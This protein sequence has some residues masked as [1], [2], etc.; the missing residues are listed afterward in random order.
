MTQTHQWKYF[1]LNLKSITMVA[2]GYL[3]TT[4]LKYSFD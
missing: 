4:I 2:S 1:N 3:N